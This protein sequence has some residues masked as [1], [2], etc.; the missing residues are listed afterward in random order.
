MNNQIKMIPY[1]G[2]LIQDTK[3]VTYLTLFTI[4]IDFVVGMKSKDAS[5][6]YHKW[7]YFSV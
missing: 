4:F 7:F 6:E 3:D 5:S 2:Q 1:R